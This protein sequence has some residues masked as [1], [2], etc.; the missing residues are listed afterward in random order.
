MGLIRRYVKVSES[1]P[2][3]GMRHE[4][5]RTYKIKKHLLCWLHD[6]IM[7]LALFVSAIVFFG[8]LPVSLAQEEEVPEGFVKAKTEEFQCWNI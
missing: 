8:W 5:C 1:Q 6:M 7:T 3:N 4:M 2:G